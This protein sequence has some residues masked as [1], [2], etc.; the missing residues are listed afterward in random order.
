MDWAWIEI[1]LV[2][3]TNHHAWTEYEFEAKKVDLIL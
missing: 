2:F 3:V 1:L